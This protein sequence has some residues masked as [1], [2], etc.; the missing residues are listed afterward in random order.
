M[1]ISK[2]LKEYIEISFLNH[3]YTLRS[4]WDYIDSI[5]EET[6]FGSMDLYRKFYNRL[7]TTFPDSTI[8]QLEQKRK[9]LNWMEEEMQGELE[10]PEDIGVWY[11]D[12]NIE[13][14]HG[15]KNLQPLWKRDII[16][17]HFGEKTLENEPT[18]WSFDNSYE[19]DFLAS[20]SNYEIVSICG[21][22]DKD[23][24]ILR[25]SNSIYEFV[26]D[27]GEQWSFAFG[28]GLSEGIRQNLGKFLDDIELF[29]LYKISMYI[30]IGKR[31]VELDIK[32]DQ[33]S[34]KIWIEN[35]GEKIKLDT[36]IQIKNGPHLLVEANTLYGQQPQPKQPLDRTFMINGRI[37]S[38]DIMRL[39]PNAVIND[40]IFG[41]IEIGINMER[42]SYTERSP[43]IDNYYMGTLIAYANIRN[44]NVPIIN[45]MNTTVKLNDLMLEEMS[46]VTVNRI[47]AQLE[48]IVN[49]DVICIDFPKMTKDKKNYISMV[50]YK[51][52]S[53]T[54]WHTKWFTGFSE[55]VNKHLNVLNTGEKND[56]L[57]VEAVK[58]GNV[59]GF[60]S[61]TYVGYNTYLG[62]SEIETNGVFL[63]Y[64]KN[65]SLRCQEPVKITLRILD[66]NWQGERIVGF[67]YVQYPVYADKYGKPTPIV[68]ISLTDFDKNGEYIIE[69]PN[70]ETSH[71]F[72]P[73]RAFK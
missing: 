16:E 20:L 40:S 58:G 33:D 56:T 59:Y 32:Y 50:K 29:N 61:Y 47:P 71:H 51:F 11:F 64:G 27:D 68:N 34:K 72:K 4:Y 62:H 69:I 17:D 44:K 42:L 46:D 1:K 22:Y 8:Q 66:K 48:Q 35:K 10:T 23:K 45:D 36:P 7:R 18:V 55:G 3:N 2:D 60:I 53:E 9:I 19:G 28:T 26:I 14:Y 13:L 65:V 39:L 43:D 31:F 57:T 37:T 6:G 5:S 70:L 24:K 63:A 54:E 52:D 41:L 12:E 21:F 49:K 30:K 15:T 73:V 25:S 67:E 38:R